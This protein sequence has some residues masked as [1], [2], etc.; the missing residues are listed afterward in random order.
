[1]VISLFRFNIGNFGTIY[2]HITLFVLSVTHYF[3]S[4]LMYVKVV[5][6]VLPHPLSCVSVIFLLCDGVSIF[7]VFLNMS[8]SIWTHLMLILLILTFDEVRDQVWEEMILDIETP[9]RLML[10]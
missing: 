4:I 2:F 9:L 8:R 3:V 10:L 5:I 6:P 1:M 7:I